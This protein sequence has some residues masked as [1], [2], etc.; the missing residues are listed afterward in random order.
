[1]TIRVLIDVVAGAARWQ[2]P[3]RAALPEAQFHE[4]DGV[5]EVD[6]VIAWRPRAETF[7]RTRVRKAIL[8]LGAGVE[9]LLEVPTLPVDVP[10]YRLVDAGMARQMAEYA[11]ATVL[12]VHRGFDQYAEDQRAARWQPREPRDKASFGVGVLGLGVLGRAV[13]DALRPFGFPLCGY[14]RTPCALPGVQVFAGDAALRDFL[15][16]CSVCICLLPAT[17]ATRDLFDRTRLSWLP[18]GAHLVN[19]ARG[20]LVVDADLVEA[21]DAGHI[22]GATLDVFRDEPLPAGHPFWHHPK[23]AVTPHVSALTRVDES[24][25]QVAAAIRALESGREPPGRVDRAR[26]Y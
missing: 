10:V 21:L 26:G 7:A 20:A 25:A 3:F 19:V 5:D 13:I 12:R 22:A 11:V 18:R 16:R 24:V 17:P 6:Y 8:N 9:A 15:G 4:C 14:T 1:M 2:A 23:V